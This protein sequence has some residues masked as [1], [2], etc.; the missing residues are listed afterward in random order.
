[1]TISGYA[2]GSPAVMTISGYAA[3]IV[4][5]VND[6][7]R[8]SFDDQQ[9]HVRLS[10]WRLGG[11][12]HCFVTNPRPPSSLPLVGAFDWPPALMTPF[13]LSQLRASERRLKN[14]SN[15]PTKHC[16]GCPA[17]A[18][19]PA[20]ASPG[21]ASAA[22][23]LQ[24]RL[25]NRS[26]RSP[27]FDVLFYSGHPTIF[28]ASF[29]SSMDSLQSLISSFTQLLGAFASNSATSALPLLSPPSSNPLLGSSH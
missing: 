14:S 24:S 18:T 20:A 27:G 5:A 4:P 25:S 23:L 17:L 22:V 26:S 1:M 13:P 9:R 15:P 8:L 12:S 19:V 10:F 28:P 3:E 2:A 16:R 6:N 29:I 21:P 7:I 11:S